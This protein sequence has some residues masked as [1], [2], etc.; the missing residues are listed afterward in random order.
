MNS[1]KNTAPSSP[2]P[3]LLSAGLLLSV[4]YQF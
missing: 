2:V 4:Q 1:I 3:V